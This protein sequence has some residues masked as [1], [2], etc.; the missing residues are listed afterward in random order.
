[1]ADAKEKNL[2]QKI[3]AVSLAVGSLRAD[4]TNSSQNYDY[5]SADKILSVAGKKLAA[6]GI[7]IR[8]FI[9]EDSVEAVQYVNS[10][11]K[12]GT[13]WDARIAFTMIVSDG[14]NLELEDKWVGRGNDSTTPD[15]AHYK[16]LTSGHK[17]YLMK[18]LNIG[19]GNEDG[20]HEPAE[21]PAAEEDA[22]NAPQPQKAGQGATKA[23]NTANR[24]N[25]KRNAPETGNSEPVDMGNVEP[26][27]D[28]E[29]DIIG[30]WASKADAINW[31]LAV[32]AVDNEY[33]AGN[34]WMAIVRQCRGF[35]PKNAA[36]VYLLFYRDRAAKLAEI[37][38][39]AEN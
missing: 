7:V 24:T 32:G 22:H 33:A 31:A 15:K 3:A 6:A 38:E 18:L 11:G 2:I 19:V 37:L 21:E 17:Y 30:Q 20:E 23:Q 25:A 10:Y 27:T 26:P 29:L 36:V 1:M 39:N 28:E 34:A 12:T 4:K 5:I 9:E 13:R 35:S 14:G 8:A 16:A